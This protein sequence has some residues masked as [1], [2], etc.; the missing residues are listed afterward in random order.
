M[1]SVSY[2]LLSA[3]YWLFASSF[4]VLAT[5]VF[6]VTKTRIIGYVA[7]QPWFHTLVW[8]LVTLVLTTWLD[9]FQV[10][11][12]HP[13]IPHHALAT[14]SGTGPSM[15]PAAH[16]VSEALGGD[17]GAKIV[18]MAAGMVPS[19]TQS[20]AVG[21]VLDDNPMYLRGQRNFWLA[22]SV[23]FFVLANYVVVL[24]TREVVAMQRKAS[25]A[26]AGDEVKDAATE[27]RKDVTTELLDAALPGG[28]GR[29]GNTTASIA[30]SN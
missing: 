13:P 14:A 17:T 28:D 9:A 6:R 18:D 29:P 7:S 20:G 22:T 16:Q 26:G 4:V 19:L 24:N 25:Q 5:P 1:I 27:A 12:L 21:Q 23:L 3:L 2:T 30:P 15:F 11:V 8:I 10:T